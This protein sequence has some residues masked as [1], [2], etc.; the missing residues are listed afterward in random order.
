MRK[1]KASSTNFTISPTSFLSFFA[2]SFM[3]GTGEGGETFRKNFK[4]CLLLLL[5][6][7]TS[8]K[9]QEKIPRRDG[10]K[11]FYCRDRSRGEIHATVLSIC[12]FE[13]LTNQRI[14]LNLESAVTSSPLRRFFLL[15][16]LQTHRS[17]I[18]FD[19]VGSMG[20]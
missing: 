7:L 19:L 13:H 8:K 4:D 9:R 10:K 14:S 17:L 1:T 15:L 18:L 6:D 5:F 20:F 11:K 12:T 3:N 16:L 2:A